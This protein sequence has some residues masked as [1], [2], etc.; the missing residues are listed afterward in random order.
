MIEILSPGQS[1]TK[2]VKKIFH[3]LGCGTQLGWLIDPEEECVFSYTPDLKVVLHEESG[4]TLPVPEFATDF[5]LTVG[6]LVLGY[7]SKGLEHS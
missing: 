2:I 6:E 1:Q 3:A 5:C 4:A 7:M